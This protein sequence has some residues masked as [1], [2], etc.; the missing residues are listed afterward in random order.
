M[1]IQ[2][3]SLVKINSKIV[4]LPPV[5]S[6]VARF[7]RLRGYN[8]LYVC[9]TDEYGTSTETKAV[10]EGLTPRQICDKYNALHTEIYDWF[11]ISFDKFGRTTTEE[12]TK[13]RG[14][15]CC[16]FFAYPI[17]FLWPPSF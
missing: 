1:R 3:H 5:L 14:S 10:E 16:F 8:V 6:S 7:A 17:D 15:C 9:G 12:Q 13:E 4:F 2:I 11:N